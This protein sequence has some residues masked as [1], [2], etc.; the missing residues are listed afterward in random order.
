M[1]DKDREEPITVTDKRRIDPDTG[2]VRDNPNSAGPAPSGPG[3]DEFAG[4]SPEEAGKAAE[5]LADLQRVQADFANYRQE[6]K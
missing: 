2:Q 4:E 1:S 3:P 6:R 5:L